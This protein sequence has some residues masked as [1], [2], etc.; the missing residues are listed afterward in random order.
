LFKPEVQRRA[1]GRL[2]ICEYY[3]YGRFGVHV[4]VYVSHALVVSSSM[5]SVLRRRVICLGHPARLHIRQMGDV[6]SR[7]VPLVGRWYDGRYALTKIRGIIGRDEN[8][9]NDKQDSKVE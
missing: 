8:Q 5:C 1:Q 9:R 7:C 2:V 3:S 6:C 4:C